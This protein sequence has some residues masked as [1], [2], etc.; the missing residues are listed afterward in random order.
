MLQAAFEAG[1]HGHRQIAQQGYPGHDRGLLAGDA[2]RT[3]SSR[4]LAQNRFPTCLF[5]HMLSRNR[6]RRATR[7][8]R[9]LVHDPLLPSLWSTRGKSPE[10][11]T[12]MRPLSTLCGIFQ[13]THRG[14]G[15][16]IEV[17][18]RAGFLSAVCSFD[19][20]YAEVFWVKLYAGTFEINEDNIN[21]HAS[22]THLTKPY[23]GTR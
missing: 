21:K 15:Q 20:W 22:K 2:T 3:R 10:E 18:K 7:V 14:I 13:Q 19:G 16:D 17:G 12:R 9:P 23:D 1:R 4:C 5:V 6:L 11:R 8:L